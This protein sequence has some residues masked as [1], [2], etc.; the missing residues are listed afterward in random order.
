MEQE[1]FFLESKG[2][3]LNV[4]ILCYKSKIKIFAPMLT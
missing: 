1:D 3:K 2:A 4:K